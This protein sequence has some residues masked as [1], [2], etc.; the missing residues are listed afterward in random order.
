MPRRGEPLYLLDLHDLAD[1]VHCLPEWGA[2]DKDTGEICMFGMLVPGTRQTRRRE[3]TGLSP[4]Q[5][6]VEKSEQSGI[7]DVYEVG[8][9]C[10]RI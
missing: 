5:R 4:Y 6:M 1:Y 3:D 8:A 10:M 7:G 9:I 2:C